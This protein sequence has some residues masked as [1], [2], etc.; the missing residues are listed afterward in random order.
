MDEDEDYI[1]PEVEEDEE[2]DGLADAIEEEF[3]PDDGAAQEDDEVLSD[4]ADENESVSEEE[5]DSDIEEENGKKKK[6][7]SKRKAVTDDWKPLSMEELSIKPF[8]GADKYKKARV[9]IDQMYVLSLHL[10]RAKWSVFTF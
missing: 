1:A 2:I 5:P 9:T 10:L 8:K 3:V 4:Y 6:R 7:K